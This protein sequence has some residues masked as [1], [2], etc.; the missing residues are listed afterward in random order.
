MIFDDI[1]LQILSEHYSHTFD[2]LQSYLK[3]RD[4]LFAGI[5]FLLIIMLFQLY[6]PQETSNLITQL[7][8]EKLNLTI[9]INFLYIQSVLWFILLATVI[10]YFQS[11]VF[12]EHQY[13]YIHNIED[14]LSIEYEKKAF[15]R[16][17]FSYLN[18]FPI[19]LK[20]VSFLYTIFFPILLIIITISKFVCEC[21]ITDFKFLLLL[22]NG[23]ICL[24]ILIS[25]AL[26][27]WAIHF[28]KKEMKENL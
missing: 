19:L 5:L 26:Y 27:F 18:N 10:K 21:K 7:I 9:P 22:F 24:F 25:T 20:W 6:T 1:K 23:I 4:K 2:F 14:L 11:V 3:K 17:G 16:E 13:N 12:I 15:T 8:S 28:N